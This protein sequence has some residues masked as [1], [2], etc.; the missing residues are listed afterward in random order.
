MSIL[1]WKWLWIKFLHMIC[2]FSHVILIW[3]ISFHLWSLDMIHFISCDF[4]LIHFFLCESLHYSFIFTHD[5]F[6]TWFFIFFHKTLTHSCFHVILM[7]DFFFYCYT[8]FLHMIFTH[9]S[10]ISMWLV[11]RIHLFHRWFLHNSSS[12][13]RDFLQDSLDVI[14]IW[15]IYCSTFLTRFIYFSHLFSFWHCLASWFLSWFI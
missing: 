6:F 8:C 1:Y 14:L 5:S 4:N 2:F 10:F 3:F 7:H 12:F 11:H 9:D 13:T 15:L